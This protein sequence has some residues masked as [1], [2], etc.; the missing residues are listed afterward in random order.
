MKR[1]CAA[2]ENHQQRRRG[3]CQLLFLFMAL[4]VIYAVKLILLKIMQEADELLR[5]FSF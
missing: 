2:G 3:V 1:Y 4:F 5:E